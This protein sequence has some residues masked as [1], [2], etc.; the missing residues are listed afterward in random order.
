[1]G[2]RTDRQDNSVICALTM[3]I[4]DPENRNGNEAEVAACLRVSLHPNAVG[5]MP[6]KIE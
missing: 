3:D 2:W 6:I 4:D 5:T 1:M